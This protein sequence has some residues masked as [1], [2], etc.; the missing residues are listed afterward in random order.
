[1]KEARALVEEIRSGLAR[2]RRKILDHP[3]LEALERG[4]VSSER[5]RGFA[6][7]QYHNLAIGLRSISDLVGRHGHLPSRVFLMNVLQGQS[8]AKDALSGFAA[9]LDLT[10]EHLSSHEPSPEGQ[11]YGHFIAWLGAYGSDAELAAAYLEGAE[12]WAANC[13]RMSRA[14]KDRYGFDEKSCAF[15]DL[16]AAGDGAEADALPVIQDALNRGIDPRL[17]FRAARLLQSYELMFWNGMAAEAEI[18]T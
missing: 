13:G 7:Q 4:G 12:T 1:M 11:A 5:L 6:G 8:A 9:G 2:T 15:L 14:L 18:T 16:Y 3:Y 10:E 17:M